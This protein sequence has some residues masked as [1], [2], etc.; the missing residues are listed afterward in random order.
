METKEFGKIEIVREGY[1]VGLVLRRNKAGI[2]VLEKYFDDSGENMD[3][4]HTFDDD[5]IDI[6][7]SVKTDFYFCLAV[8]R[9]Y[10]P[11]LKCPIYIK[12]NSQ[13]EE[14]SAEEKKARFLRLA[15]WSERHPWSKNHC[16][17]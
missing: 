7:L 2:V 8:A 6:D 1:P 14:E 16:P 5:E 10:E 3:V 4:V 17:G 11:D 9:E 12:N 15:E 13:S